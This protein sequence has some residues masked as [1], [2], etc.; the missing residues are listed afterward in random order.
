MCRQILEG[1]SLLREWMVERYTRL[2]RG[3]SYLEKHPSYKKKTAAFKAI[4]TPLAK[5][6]LDRQEVDKRDF[7]TRL[8]AYVKG[9][10]INFELNDLW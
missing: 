5:T 9:E 4:T 1:E 2:L 8:L 3:V 7:Y 10:K 6:E